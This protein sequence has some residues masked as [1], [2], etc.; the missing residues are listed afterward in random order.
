MYNRR[1]S[2]I[3]LHP[4]ALPG[5]GGIGDIGDAAYRFIDWLV[6]A[7]QRRW[8]I[9]PLGP[10]SYGDS[11]YAGLSA[12]AGNPLLIALEQLVRAGW[13]DERAL[14]DAPGAY[15]DWIDYGAVIPWKMARLEWAFGGFRAHA[16]A[17]Q[18]AAFAEF[19]AEHASWLDTFTL[20]AA[21]KEAYRGEP[22]NRW[23]T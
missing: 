21:L 7:K 23:D 12:L 18:R 10:T 14:T 17:E 22:W 3:L 9:M 5:A 2:G 1:V 15:G 13:L 6:V 19:C 16:N 8:Q 20:F 4:A 11:P